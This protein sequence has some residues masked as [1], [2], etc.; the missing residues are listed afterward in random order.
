MKTYQ[1]DDDKRLTFTQFEVLKAIP[2]GQIF[3]GAKHPGTWYHAD[4]YAV[5]STMLSLLERKLVVADPTF[6]DGRRGAKVTQAGYAAMS[7]AARH[8][9]VKRGR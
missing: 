1:T 6:T 3:I 2:R 9:P 7:Y 5:T 4:G 8:K